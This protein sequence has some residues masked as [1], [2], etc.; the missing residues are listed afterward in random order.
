MKSRTSGKKI[1][2]GA[3]FIFMESEESVSSTSPCLLTIHAF[4]LSVIGWHQIAVFG[5]L[6]HFQSIPRVR[7]ATLGIDL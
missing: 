5:G 4:E 1:D 2:R 3:T 7:T 6:I